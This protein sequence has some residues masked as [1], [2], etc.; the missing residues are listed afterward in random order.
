M[1]TEELNPCDLPMAI[2][3]KIAITR[4][5]E[6]K[7][8]EHNLEVLKI[9][10]EDSPGQ[11]RTSTG[12]IIITDKGLEAFKVFAECAKIKPLYRGLQTIFIAALEDNLLLGELWWGDFLQQYSILKEFL[13]QVEDVY[14]PE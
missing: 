8:V 4:S 6:T 13:E 9:E 12:D 5:G 14:G 10:I 11:N 1:T 7:I 3:L 2:N